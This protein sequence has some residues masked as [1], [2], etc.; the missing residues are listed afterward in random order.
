MTQRL[1]LPRSESRLLLSGRP[2]F[3]E[4]SLLDLFDQGAGPTIATP[5]PVV[6]APYASAANVTTSGAR[7]LSVA[8]ADPE[9][10]VVMT[11]ANKPS[12]KFWSRWMVLSKVQM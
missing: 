7:A 12:T 1:A 10:A 5:T 9:W 11:S 2:N 3:E 8:V 4:I 6:S